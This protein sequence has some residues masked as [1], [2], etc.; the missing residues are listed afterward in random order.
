MH[1]VCGIRQQGPRGG[2]CAVGVKFFPTALM[3]TATPSAAI[4]PGVGENFH[5][6]VLTGV[7]REGKQQVPTGKPDRRKVL[8]RRRW[9]VG[10]WRWLGCADDLKARRCQDGRDSANEDPI[11]VGDVGG[12]VLKRH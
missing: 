8:C 11:V 6:H 1:R 9:L 7:I 5:N 2:L 12:Q 3:R 4:S 10:F